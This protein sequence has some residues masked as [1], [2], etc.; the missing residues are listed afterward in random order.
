MADISPSNWSYATA[1]HLLLRSG[2]GHNGTY[3]KTTSEVSQ[4]RHFA[5]LTPQAAVSELL[6]IRAS[7]VKGP[8]TLDGSDADFAKL[9]LWWI[10]R[11]IRT[12]NP[13]AEKMVLFL[14][15]HFATARSKVTK[16]LYMATQNA[17]FRQFAL[18]SFR[19]L[20]KQVT[21]DAAMLWWLDGNLNKI[22]RPNENYA[23]ELQELFT[24]G[25]FDFNNQGNYTQKDVT[26]AARI[27]TGWRF[28]EVKKKIVVAFLPSRHDTLAKTI[29]EGTPSQIDVP[30]AY[31]PP[32]GEYKFFIDQILDKH[33]DSDGRPTAA[34]FLTRKLWKFF[35]YDPVV[36]G[37]NPPDRPMIDAL[38]DVFVASDYS[39][40]AVLKAMFLREEFYADAT[41]T[42][43]GPTEYVV[44][45]LRML[46]AKLTGSTKANI[47]QDLLA[48]M[49]QELL[50]PPD[51]FSWRGNLA[52]ITTQTMLRRYAFGAALASG[53]LGRN[54]ELGHNVY[55]YLNTNETTRAGVVDHFLNLLGI[56]NIDNATRGELIQWLGSSDSALDLKNPD[57]VR[58]RVRG[59]LNLILTLPHYHVH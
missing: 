56:F 26:G 48:N 30:A 23:R 49:G 43:K 31:S 41:R 25:V 36:E 9:Q 1:A 37:V 18:G 2:F 55:A 29:Y 24:L 50:N 47:G 16:P 28:S 35:A 51:V 17:L 54:S 22:G 10:N 19:E 44:G 45:S 42:V 5:N 57:Y 46:K 15:T 58:V 12:P 21:V 59:L 13:L 32:E 52:W 27:L 7:K 4:I 3:N 34:R 38:A 11:M 39:L 33:R 6:G 40:T 8:G 14:H 53:D 20:V